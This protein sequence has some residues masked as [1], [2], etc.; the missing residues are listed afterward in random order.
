MSPK[1]TKFA[2]GGIVE[3]TMNGGRRLAVVRR[4]RYGD[5]VLPKG[6]PDGNESIEETAIREVREETGCDVRIVGDG[7][8]IEYFVGRALKVVTFFRMEHV[9]DGYYRIDPSEIEE[10]V[11]LQPRE[12]VARLTYETERSILRQAYKRE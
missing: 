12:A 7:Y 5:W 8:S 1:P 4:T 10:V 3:R 9:A 2:A 6:K 11:W